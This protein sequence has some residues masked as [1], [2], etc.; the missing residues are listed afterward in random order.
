MGII[1]MIYLAI[2][3]LL[4]IMVENAIR[5]LPNNIIDNICGDINLNDISIRFVILLV[6]LFGWPII[7]IKLILNE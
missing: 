1:I 5:T 7:I 2:G 4:D 3:F 6:C